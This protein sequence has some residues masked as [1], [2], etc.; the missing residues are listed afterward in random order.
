[1][2][3]A[4]LQE[5]QRVLNVPKLKLKRA[6]VT[7]WLSH[8]STVDALRRSLKAVKAILEEEVCE[9]EATA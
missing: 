5:M 8:E 2:H 9:G 1:M 4:E 7:H 3:T 6:S